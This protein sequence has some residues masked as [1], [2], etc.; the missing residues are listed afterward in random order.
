MYCK[1]LTTFVLFILLTGCQAGTPYILDVAYTSIKPGSTIT[2]HKALNIP[3]HKARVYLQGGKVVAANDID[4]YYPN[5]S[6]EVKTLKPG[7][8]EIMEDTFK[9]VKVTS[10]EEVSGLGLVYAS[11]RYASDDQGPVSHENWVTH[12]YLSSAKQPDVYR[13]TCGHWEDPADTHPRHLT[14]PEIMK[15]VGSFF[16]FG[17]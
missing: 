8:Q 10:D 1:K 3:A 2:L 14:L 11:R 13:L 9:I 5:C 15:A 6:L 4:R 16:T 7:T 12:F 17:S